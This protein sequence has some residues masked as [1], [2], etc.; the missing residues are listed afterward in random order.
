MNQNKRYHNCFQNQ[1]IL[2]C[3]MIIL[4]FTCV[5]GLSEFKDYNNQDRNT[6]PQSLKT[7]SSLPLSALNFYKSRPKGLIAQEPVYKYAALIGLVLLYP[8]GQSAFVNRIRT[9][10]S[11]YN[12]ENAEKIRPPPIT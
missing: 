12:Y 4:L 1:A 6:Q 8:P 5:L 2:P 11:F 3:S 7:S 10:V 9:R